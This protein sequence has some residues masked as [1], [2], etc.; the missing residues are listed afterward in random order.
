[1]MGL[2]TETEED[3]LAIAELAK[4]VLTV[5]RECAGRGKGGIQVSVSVSSFVPKPQTPFQWEAQDRGRELAGKQKLLR[6]ALGQIRAVSLALHQPESSL[7]EAVLARGDRRLSEVIKLA[8]QAGCHFDSWQEQFFFSRWQE[9]F[10]KAGL[11]PAFYA[12]RQRSK[13]ELLPWEHLQSGV[14]KSF[15]WQERTRAYAG[16]RTADCRAGCNGC[17][18]CPNLGVANRFASE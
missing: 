14:N 6:E 7:L 8:W 11:D 18:V 4:K 17:G 2:P 10:A 1:M 3:I 15:L 9:A 5:G 13:E 12:N 16:E